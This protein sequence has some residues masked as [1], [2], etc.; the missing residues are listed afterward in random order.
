MFPFMTSV[1]TLYSPQSG[2]E[3]TIRGERSLVKKIQAEL[4]RVVTGLRE[5]VVLGVV[6]PAQQH[7]VLIGHGGQPL[8]ELEKRTGAEIQFPGSRSYNQVAPAENAAELEE[9][10]PKNIVKV[11]GPRAAC[12]KAIAELLDAVAKAPG[13]RERKEQNRERTSSGPVSIVQIPFKH[14]HLLRP[15]GNLLRDLRSAGV[16][17]SQEGK[18]QYESQ[19][20][21]R[22]DDDVEVDS[23]GVEWK[24]V[25]YGAGTEEG[26][27]ELTLK[28]R[29]AESL[30]LAQ[31]VLKE[32]LDK[33]DA[34]TH[35]GYMTF[36]DRGTFPRIIGNKGAVIN[37][38]SVESGAEIIVPRDDVTIKIYG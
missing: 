24:L 22:I 3:V 26:S 32:T 6:I 29:D 38:L 23:H 18:P 8:M 33:A 15:N 10:D 9:A 14:Y 20:N 36:P 4:E 1:L 28:A 12:E 17:F 11:V 5:R 2:D 27:T 37:D 34:I 25:P 19:I 21:G 16:H 30:E 35:I 7:R 13:N 31:K